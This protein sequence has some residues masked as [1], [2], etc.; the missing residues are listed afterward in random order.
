MLLSNDTLHS[1]IYNSGGV[2]IRPGTLLQVKDKT[3]CFVGIVSNANYSLPGYKV[4]FLNYIPETNQYGII[5]GS[6]F[7]DELSSYADK[8][9]G[10]TEPYNLHYLYIKEDISKADRLL[11]DK[12]CIWF[13]ALW[14]LSEDDLTSNFIKKAV[15]SY[16]EEVRKDSL[17]EYKLP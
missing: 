2:M 4:I 13:D 7:E 6:I 10:Y 15:M 11:I 17:W 5:R 1:D 9:V 12:N 8:C 3:D 16:C 14:N